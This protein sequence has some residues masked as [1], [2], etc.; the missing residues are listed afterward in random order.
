MRAELW[1]MELLREH[2]HLNSAVT[3]QISQIRPLTGYHL[4][5]LARPP[6]VSGMRCPGNKG[7]QQ[8][9]SLRE[10]P[11]SL[12]GVALGIPA[13]P[14]AIT[15]ESTTSRR[16]LDLWCWTWDLCLWTID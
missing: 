12:S 4:P 6:P 3:L 8:P 14:C 15:L 2:L 5:T 10:A 13:I 1:I 7:K 11:G 9:S 16:R